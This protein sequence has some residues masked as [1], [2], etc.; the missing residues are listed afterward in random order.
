[1][2]GTGIRERVAQSIDA[3]LEL[4]ER[5]RETWVAA[6]D[7]NTSGGDPELDLI[8][9]EA[10]D[11]AV[12]HMTEVVGLTALSHEHAEVRS[13]FRAYS[14]MA[15]TTT[16]EWLKQGRLTRPQ[17]HILLEEILLNLIEVVVPQLVET[18]EANA[19]GNGQEQRQP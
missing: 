2:P 10:R 1:V 15:E 9:E 14:G 7:M 19:R 16:R 3:W 6:L 13:A 12:D 8:L 18:A 11:R 4:L 5:N 17:V